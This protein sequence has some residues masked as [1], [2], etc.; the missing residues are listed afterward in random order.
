MGRLADLT[1]V[2]PPLALLRL[3]AFVPPLADLTAVAAPPHGQ[4]TRV[5][6]EEADRES[7][8]AT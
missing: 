2:A 7:T 5:R 6:E 4:K 8:Q 1:A 3:A